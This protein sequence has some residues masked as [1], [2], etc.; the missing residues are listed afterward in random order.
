[1]T[2]ELES[3]KN[4]NPQAKKD[5]PIAWL[6]RLLKGFISGVGAITPGLSGG[7]MMVVF[8]I[9]EPLLKWLADI[10]QNFLRNL[11]FFIPV[12][13]GGVVGVV[14]FS[15]AID[16]AYELNAVMFTW[17]IIGFIVGTYPS[18]LRTAGKE[19]RKAWHIIMMLV[20]AGVLFYALRWMQ[21]NLDISMP[22]NFWIWMMCGA[23][24][25][26]GLI[27]PGLSPSNFLMYMGLYQPMAAGVK[28]LNFGVII[29][30]LLGLVTVIFALAKLISWLFKKHYALLYH[31]IL[32]VVFGSTLAIVPIV[33]ETKGVMIGAD[34]FPLDKFPQLATINEPKSIVICV[35]LALAGF[36]ASFLLAKLDEKHPHES[37]F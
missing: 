10:R 6:V 18:I 31:I 28:T 22:Q 19:G 14:A 2:Q 29:P 11:L 8:G 36:A 4:D 33:S 34:A 5:T 25:G 16:K 1:M 12:G 17:L 30:M 3:K 24:T 15:A 27:V 20:I 37:L 13:I 26:L 7:V 21:S 35:L 9:Y 32:G 23:L